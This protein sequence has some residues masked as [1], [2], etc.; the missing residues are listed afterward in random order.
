MIIETIG[1]KVLNKWVGF[2]WSS[3]KRKRLGLDKA[4]GVMGGVVGCM[5]GN[6]V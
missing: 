4:R 3:G 5:Q 6:R 1:E 2:S